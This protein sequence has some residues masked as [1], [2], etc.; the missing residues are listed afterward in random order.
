M[1][2]C[3]SHNGSKSFPHEH[4]MEKLVTPYLKGKDFGNLET[5]AIIVLTIA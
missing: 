1:T 5:E 2:F 3:Y 4:E